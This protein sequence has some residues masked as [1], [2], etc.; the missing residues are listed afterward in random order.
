MI[1]L[2]LSSGQGPAECCRAVALAVSHITRQCHKAGVGLTVIETTFSDNKEGYKSI[3]LRLYSA[4]DD[5]MAT[6]LAHQWQGSMLWVC[7]SPYRPRHKRKNWFFSGAVTEVDEHTMSKEIT[8]QRCRAS[9]A[10]GQHVNTTDSAVR[11][12]H[13]QTGICVRAESERS[14]HANKRI[15][16][17]LIFNKLEAMKSQQRHDQAKMR[18]QQH[19]TLERGAPKRTFTG[20][21]FKEKR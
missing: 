7:Q 19:Q 17:A 21:Q 9:G 4:D 6:Q 5:A 1:L 13:T 2:Q 14:Q 10:G 15:A 11:A 3:L 16:I 20:E 18:W 8:F 12:T